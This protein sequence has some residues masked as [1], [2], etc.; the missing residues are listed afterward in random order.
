MKKIFAPLMIS[1]AL[2]VT[3]CA[4]YDHDN[5]DGHH[6]AESG[7]HE[8]MDKGQMDHGAMDHGSMGHGTENDSHG[9]MMKD[10]HKDVSKEGSHGM[11]HGDG[12]GEGRGMGH[13]DSLAGK[14]GIESNV[15]RSIEVEAGDN[16]RF[17]HEPFNIKE[18]ETIK[19]IVTN[20]GAIAHE[21]SIGTKNE[22]VSHGKMMMENPNMHHGP[23]GASITVKPGSTETL[24]WTFDKAW[25]IEVACN[26]PGHYEAGMHSPINI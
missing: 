17:T 6:M 22:H 23:G 21:F 16:M 11:D 25:E 13:G 26:I 1:T 12:H 3:A 14:P 4:N 7:H 2:F 15:S 9:T 18:G 20:K 5:E 10:H 8:K 19:F 24:I